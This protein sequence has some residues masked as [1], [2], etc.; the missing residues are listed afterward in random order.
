[1][2]TQ[3]YFLWVYPINEPRN[4]RQFIP[5]R[6]RVVRRKTRFFQTDC[7]LLS[8]NQLPIHQ[9]RRTQRDSPQVLRRQGRQHKT[10]PNSENH[11]NIGKNTLFYKKQTTGHRSLCDGDSTQRNHRRVL[12]AEIFQ[13]GY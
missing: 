4:Y 6:R 12:F 7:Q 2:F 9:H 1:M 5:G 10:H 3:V 8:R 13:P 11:P